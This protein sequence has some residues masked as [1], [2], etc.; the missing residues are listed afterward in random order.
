MP[1]AICPF[2]DSVVTWPS[3]IVA[4]YG[5]DVVSVAPFNVPIT[6]SGILELGEYKDAELGFV[7]RVRLVDARIG[8]APAGAGHP[9]T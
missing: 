3:D 5:R 7:S 1:M 2:C 6:V 9:L 4:I 8:A